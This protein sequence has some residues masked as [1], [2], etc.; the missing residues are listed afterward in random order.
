MKKKENDLF[1]EIIEEENG[2]R[3]N[4]ISK[5]DLYDY[6]WVLIINVDYINEFTKYQLQSEININKD[7]LLKYSFL[8]VE[9]NNKLIFINYDEYLNSCIEEVNYFE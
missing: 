5:D 9:Q 1:F 3:L 7:L 2:L 6:D 4:E 8:K